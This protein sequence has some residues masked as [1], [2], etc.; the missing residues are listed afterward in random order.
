M[1]RVRQSIFS[2]TG[3]VVAIV[4]VAGVVAWILIDGLAPFS[5]GPLNA[6]A[7][8]KPLGGVTNHAQL[9]N[10]CGACHPAPWSSQTMNDLCVA[11]HADVAKEIKS[12]G[13]HAS[14]MQ[15]TPQCEGC[16]PDHNG[17]NA[18]LTTVD[19]NQFPFKL[20]GAHAKVPC[21][22]CHAGAKSLADFKSAPQDCYSCHAKQDKHNGSF[23]KDCGNC[24]STSS[25][26]GA[27]FDHA[28]FPVNHGTDQQP[29]TCKT[30][31]PN[32]TSTYTCYGCHRHTQ[33]NVMSTHENRNLAAL[34]DCIRCHPQGRQ[35]GD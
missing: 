33:Q 27:S 1:A 9:S 35:G 28:I 30:C 18:M 24:H 3:I 5:S 8:G 2:R 25:W 4:L 17:P 19:H 12:G 31:H 34:A 20:T 26:S 7:T 13:I 15:T 29:S 11:C 22:R 10:D 21:S 14:F 16:H 6:S 32:G 23:G